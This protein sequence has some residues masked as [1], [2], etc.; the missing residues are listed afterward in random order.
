MFRRICV[1]S[2]S[3]AAEDHR[4]GERER[5]TGR[6]GERERGREGER[7]YICPK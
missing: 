7:A 3:Q 6:E 4:E 2:V 1:V 5:G